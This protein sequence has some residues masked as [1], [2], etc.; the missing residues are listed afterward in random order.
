MIQRRSGNL[1][2]RKESCRMDNSAEWAIEGEED[3]QLV[4]SDWSSVVISAIEGVVAK[5]ITSVLTNNG[6]LTEVWRPDWH[7][8]GLLVGQVFQRVLEADVAC[9]WHAHRRT[10]DR[11]FCAMGRL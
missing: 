8:D 5:Q 11:L 9:G 7:L 4:R 2:E 10:T 1:S 3:R 6:Y